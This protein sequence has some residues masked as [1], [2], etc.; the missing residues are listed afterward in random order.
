MGKSRHLDASDLCIPEKI[1]AEALDLEK[2]PSDQN[3]ADALTKYAD[4]EI[5]RRAL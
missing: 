2:I 4:A 1:K 3:P 5:L